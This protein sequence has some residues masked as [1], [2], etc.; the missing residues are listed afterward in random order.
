LQDPISQLVQL[1]QSRKEKEPVFTVVSE[2][3]IPRSPE[4]VVK[5]TV[6][7]FEATGIGAKKKDAKRA[8]AL[9]ALEAFGIVNEAV[10]I[11][12][13]N[14]DEEGNVAP[15]EMPADLN[16]INGKN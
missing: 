9:K 1:Q 13:Q 7:T 10:Q 3:G 5:V 6:G 15:S 16:F 12:A 4:F 14:N 2:R 11:T 8:A